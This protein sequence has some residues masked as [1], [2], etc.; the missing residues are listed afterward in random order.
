[1]WKKKAW[2]ESPKI[3]QKQKPGAKVNTRSQAGVKLLGEWKKLARKVRI[4]K[5][6]DDPSSRG[7]SHDFPEEKEEI[8]NAI[9]HRYELNVETFRQRFRAYRYSNSDGPREAY[10]ER[11]TGEQ[12]LEMIAL[13]QFI[14]ILPDKVKLWVQEHRP[15]TSTKAISL[16]EDFL[17]ARREAEQRITVRNKPLLQKEP[18]L[19]VNPQDRGNPK[20]H[21]CGRVG[22]CEIL[23]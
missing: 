3:T 22:H 20:C 16:A 6:E 19:R 1:M 13:E 7:P 5:Q 18:Q 14:E 15:E 21:N 12:I 11:K 2:R 4:S 23:P 10:P 17:L 8:T 9:F